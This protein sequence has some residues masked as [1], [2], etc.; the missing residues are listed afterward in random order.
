MTGRVSRWRIAVTIALLAAGY[1][2]EQVA[3][4][5]RYLMGRNP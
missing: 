3:H 1:L 5:L 2:A 4:C